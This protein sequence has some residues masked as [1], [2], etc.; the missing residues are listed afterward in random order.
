MTYNPL[1]APGATSYPITSPTYLLLRP[2]YTDAAKGKAV[3]GFV[4]WLLTDGQQFAAGVGYS[5]LPTELQTK[6]L[7]QLDKVQ[8]S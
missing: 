4:K 6:A 5:K 3:K 1:N 2:T 7:A 8:T